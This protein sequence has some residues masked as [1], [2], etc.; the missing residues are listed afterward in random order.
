L[1]D[2][3]WE[4]SGLSNLPGIWAEVGVEAILQTYHKGKPEASETG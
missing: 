1:N 4:P 3:Q 2:L